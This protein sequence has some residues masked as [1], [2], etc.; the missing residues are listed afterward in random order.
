[1]F[2]EGKCPGFRRCCC[3]RYDGLGDDGGYHVRDGSW[4]QLDAG[5]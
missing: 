2:V 5:V 3:C 1:M 4:S